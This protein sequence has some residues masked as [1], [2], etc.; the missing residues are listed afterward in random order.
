MSYLSADQVLNNAYDSTEKALKIT[1]GAGTAVPVSMD[2]DTDVESVLYEGGGTSNALLTKT[3][4]ND[5]VAAIAASGTAVIEIGEH[6]LIDVFLQNPTQSQ[7]ATLVW[8]EF[9]TEVPT[10][11]TCIRVVEVSIPTTDLTFTVDRS[12]VE[13]DAATAHYAKSPVRIVATPGKYGML[14]VSASLGGSWYGRYILQA[15]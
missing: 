15:V 1:G 3:T 11:L 12:M 4:L 2:I 7:S 5:L 13:L 10:A 9:S 8:C 14:C 6:N